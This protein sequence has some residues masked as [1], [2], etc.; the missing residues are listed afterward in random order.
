MKGRARG[1]KGVCGRAES[2]S[3]RTVTSGEIDDGAQFVEWVLRRMP[4]GRERPL[5]AVDCHE[6]R[7]PSRP[8]HRA[9]SFPDERATSFCVTGVD[10]SE[11]Q[12]RR[13]RWMPSFKSGRDGS[14]RFG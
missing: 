8:S 14:D 7:L 1:Y 2:R 5:S 4:D 3:R 11:K 10:A 6:G 12:F 13:I 9:Q